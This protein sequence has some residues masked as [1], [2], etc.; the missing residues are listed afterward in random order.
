MPVVLNQTKSDYPFGMGMPGRNWTAASAEEYRFGFNGKEADKETYG[1]GNEYDYGFRIYNSRLGK[2]LSI[3]PLSRSYPWYTPYQFAGNKPINCIDLDGLEELLVI[4]YFDNNNRYMGS[5]L[6]R[7]Q[8]PEQRDP[9]HRTGGDMQM[10]ELNVSNQAAIQN[11]VNSGNDI[12]NLEPILKSNGQFLGDYHSAMQP[13][14]VKDNAEIIKLNETDE[15]VRNDNS[16]RAVRF[17]TTTVQFIYDND[18]EVPSFSGSELTAIKNAL[19]NDPDRR[20]NINAYTSVEGDENY[21][22]DLSQKRADAVKDYLIANGIDE[23][24]ILE[25][26]GS[27]ETQKN[28]VGPENYE[29]NRVAEISFTYEKQQD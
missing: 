19:S 16:P 12:T 23:T 2:F 29:K 11:I 8:N 26:A 6:L 5:T 14:Y 4:R 7:V 27:G 21:N 3:D 10:I 9:G 18:T 20:I 17:I 28:G 13:Q 25:T 22:L 1:E 24:R 15:N